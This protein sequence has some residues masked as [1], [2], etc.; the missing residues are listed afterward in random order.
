MGLGL[1]LD[2]GWNHRRGFATSRHVLPYAEALHHR[3]HHGSGQG[4]NDHGFKASPIRFETDFASR[5]P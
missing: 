1:E 4:M 5:A 3:P 2:L